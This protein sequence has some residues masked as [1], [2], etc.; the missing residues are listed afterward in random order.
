MILCDMDG[1][2]ATGEAGDTATGGPI[3]RT[4]HEIPPELATIRDS[5]VSMHVVT[6][7]VESQARQV[8]HA[9]GL[10]SHFDSVVGA[11]RLFWPTVWESV[12]RRRIPRAVSKQACRRLLPD[13]RGDAVVMIEDHPGHLH[14]LLSA[15]LID[16]GILVPKISVVGGKPRTWFDLDLVFRIARSLSTHRP[17]EVDLERADITLHRWEEDGPESIDGWKNILMADDHRFLIR[18]SPLEPPDEDGRPAGADSL[19]TGEALKSAGVGVVGGV[20]L[21]RRTFRGILRRLRAL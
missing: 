2:L 20:R 3:Y 7:K 5:G 8:L 6:A 21:A 9:I 4:F 10:A 16:F 14:D 1:V 15:G 19:H 18:L 17:S 13:P 12:K 11:D